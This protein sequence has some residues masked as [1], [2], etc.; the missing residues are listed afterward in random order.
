MLT[1]LRLRSLARLVAGSL[2][3]VVVTSAMLA[4]APTPAGAVGLVPGQWMAK[5]YSEALG[6]APDQAAWANLVSVFRSKGCSAAILA[7]VGEGIYDSQEFSGLGYDNAARLLALYRGALDREPDTS[8]FNVWLGQL[9]SGVSSWPHTV[10]S[11]FTSAE[12]K[13]DAATF[14]T[15]G[16]YGFGAAPAIPIPLGQGCSGPFCFTGGTQQQLQAMLDAAPAGTT[17]TLAQQAVVRITTA[18]QIPGNRAAGLDIP[19]G[20]TLTTAGS[21]APNQYAMMGRLVRVGSLGAAAVVE[22]ESGAKLTSVWV[23]GQRTSA[24]DHVPSSENV[25]MAGGSGTTVSGD[26]LSNAVGFTNLQALGTFEGWPC[27]SNTITNNL[28]TAY[29]SSHVDGNWSDG[30]SVACENATIAGN[31]VI[32]ATDVGIV[33]FRAYPADQHSLV[34]GNT[35]LSAGN[36]AF[37]G[38]GLDPVSQ[39]PA[40]AVSPD[41]AGTSVTHN[42][43]WTSPTTSFEIALTVGTGAW[44]PQ[45]NIGSGAS[46]T[47]N[48]TG[49]QSANVTEGIAVSGIRNATVTGNT[50]TVHLEQ[51]GACPEAAIAV[52]PSL[53]SG[54]TIQTPFTSVNVRTCI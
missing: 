23:D 32:D 9:N 5:M 37:G 1:T 17:V 43:L 13:S 25:Q 28:V 24:S 14:C 54:G 15:T 39:A 12:F 7:D 21:P 19:A 44:F 16:S 40:A 53:G 50:L 52:D 31:T 18:N 11:F 42:T 10:Q 6:R 41:F 34:S 22:L 51:H 49:S 47:G 8:G 35:V 26:R 3:S 20:V 4:A 45:P 33:V 36:S 29:A 48:T 27:P 46:V 2:L 30:L 38:I